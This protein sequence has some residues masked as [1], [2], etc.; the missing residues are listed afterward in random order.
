MA[1]RLLRTETRMT[2]RLIVR[3]ARPKLGRP[4]E[5]RI[6]IESP[7]SVGSGPNNALRLEHPRVAAYQGVLTFTPT[8]VQ[9]TDCDATASAVIDGVAVKPGIRNTLRNGTL[10]QVGPFMIC[11]EL[12]ADAGLDAPP[13]AVLP[14]QRPES[15]ALPGGSGVTG[16]VRQAVESI[17]GGVPTTSAETLTSFLIRAL[18][19]ADLVA[20]AIVELR[21]RHGRLGSRPFET[22]PLRIFWDPHEIA[23]YLLDPNAPAVRLTELKRYL[24]ELAQGKPPPFSG[25]GGQ[26]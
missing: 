4:V 23:D 13:A 9:Y 11:V 15:E 6:F 3:I 14:A 26:A 20:E 1:R 18:K 21:T 5:T 17:V 12:A 7:V 10:V 2:D 8:S 25:G 22:S 19:L 16:V 24:I